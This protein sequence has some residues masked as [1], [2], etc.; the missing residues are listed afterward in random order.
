MRA[1]G[2]RVRCLLRTQWRQALVLSLIVAAV[3]G[4]VLGLAAGAARTASAPD[5]YTVAQ[6]GG[7]DGTIQ[8][9]GGP[10]RTAEVGALP[11]VASAESVTF[12]FGGLT[13]ANVDQTDVVIFAGTHTAVGLR[14]VEGREPD[15]SRPEEFVASRSFATSVGGDALG[16]T[17]D[18]S[19]L[20]QEQADRAG[21]EAFAS[22]GPRGTKATLRL[23]GIV[24]GPRLE[25]PSPIAVVAPA[26]IT[27]DD[28]VALTLIGVGLRPGTDLGALRSALDGLPDGNSLSLEPARLVGSEVRTAVEGQARGFWLLTA[29]AGLAGLVVLGQLISRSVRLSAEEGPRLKALGLNTAQVLGE[30]IARAAVPVVAG[31]VIGVAVATS[32][33]PAFPTGF[34]RR[35]EP[36]PGW[37]LDTTV[38]GAGAAAVVVLLI[39]WTVA[40]LLVDSGP[41]G[42]QRPSPLVDWV[43]VRCRSGAA[44]TGVRFAFT[45]SRRDG[46]SVRATVVGL[47]ATVALLFGTVVFTS[48]LARLVTDGRRFGQTYDLFVG[49][50]GDVVPEDLIAR[51]ENDPDVSALALYG[52]GQARIGSRSLGLVGM[53]PVKGDV[54]TQTL[55]GRLPRA[56]DEI[57]LGRLAARTL[58]AE[59]GSDLTVEVADGT[60]R[61]RVT[62]LVVVP[63]VEE[64]DGVGQGALVTMAG[65]GRSDPEATAS[66][67]GVILRRG[68]PPGTA[69]RLGL[70]E[71]GG[72]PTVILNL[73]RIRHVP[74][75]LACLVGALAVLTIVHVMLTSIHHRRRDLALL[76]SLGADRRWISRAVHWQATSSALV[77]LALGLPLGLIAGRLV[78]G[79]FADSVGAVPSASFPYGLLVF[80]IVA[81]VALAN[82]V[83][84]LPARRARRLE[85]A[86]LLAAEQ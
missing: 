20:T 45:R 79:L 70:G 18:F 46:G 12:L 34:V 80:V 36:H 41:R 74:A 3:S 28:G 26:L 77:P 67:A 50:G 63:P 85:P 31:T 24:D 4:V 16:A 47:L 23:V 43:A 49:S 7:F 39:L 73:A 78:F 15:P 51:L 48:S 65:L 33:S 61:F 5:R 19:V 2:Y 13:L 68:A 30:S 82:L 42:Q 66:A 64:I 86:A 32:L 60:R 22:E 57:A 75:L 14:L 84:A 29:V 11:G 81:F 83:A 40:A 58:G 76:R 17:F 35:L 62:G 6:G 59:V 55:S 1:V 27:P 37:Q 71:D 54:P 69:Q 10:P 72:R 25:D 53:L 56:D 38:L 8:Q 9:G 21:N 44:A 52:S